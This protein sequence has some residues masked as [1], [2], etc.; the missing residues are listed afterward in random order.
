MHFPGK[1]RPLKIQVILTAISTTLVRARTRSRSKKVRRFLLVGR[2][3]RKK[4]TRAMQERLEA[5][6]EGRQ[7]STSTAVIP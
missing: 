7:S 6:K 4:L 1:Y 2:V 3:V 5:V